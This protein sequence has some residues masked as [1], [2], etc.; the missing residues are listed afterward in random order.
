ML[1]EASTVPIEV[2]YLDHFLQDETS[3][4]AGGRVAKTER[5][6]GVRC[7]FARNGVGALCLTPAEGEILAGGFVERDHQIVRRHAGRRGDAGV[8]VFQECKPH[9]LGTLFDESEI[10]DDQVVGIMH[11]DKRRGV[12]E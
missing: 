5:S 7:W 9:L 8:D 10:E 4:A 11:G 2:S 3:R 1:A 6:R 12:E